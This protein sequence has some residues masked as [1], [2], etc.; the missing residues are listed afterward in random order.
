MFCQL[1][2]SLQICVFFQ[3]RFIFI[4]IDIQR[5][6]LTVAMCGIHDDM[7]LLFLSKRFREC[8]SELMEYVFGVSNA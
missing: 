4:H 7:A 1:T 3:L 8:K 2:C 6:F 5:Y